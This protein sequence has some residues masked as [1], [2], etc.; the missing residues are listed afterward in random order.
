MHLIHARH[1]IL[2]GVFDSDDLSV[3][4]IDTVKRRIQSGRLTRTGRPCNE[5]DTI[6]QCDDSLEGGLVIAKET[7]LGQT[8]IQAL[9]IENT[10]DDTLTKSSRQS[11]Y[12]EVNNLGTDVD[13]NTSIL[14]HALFCDTDIGHQLNTR[15]NGRL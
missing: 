5:E 6:G 12:A 10:H 9:L 15:N 7:Q 11:R 13:V 1:L 3:G 8:E 2:D 14:R 4:V